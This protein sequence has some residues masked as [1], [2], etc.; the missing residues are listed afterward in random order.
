MRRRQPT[1]DIR[2]QAHAPRGGCSRPKARGRSR[3]RARALALS[4]HRIGAVRELLRMVTVRADCTSN[5]TSKV[6]I[7]LEQLQDRRKVVARLPTQLASCFLIHV[8]TIDTREQ[9]PATPKVLR[10]AVRE[11]ALHYGCRIVV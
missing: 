6:S 4:L 1:R 10:L 9:F 3:T 8:H 7:C 2:R 11:A 5:W